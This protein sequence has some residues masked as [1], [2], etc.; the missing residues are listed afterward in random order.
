MEFNQ[1][2]TSSSCNINQRYDDPYTVIV[3]CRKQMFISH[4]G[5]E[6]DYSRHLLN[7]KS[8]EEGR[9]R[10]KVGGS[11]MFRENDD[12]YLVTSRLQKK[13]IDGKRPRWQYIYKLNSTW[14]GIEKDNPAIVSWLWDGFEAPY[15]AKKDDW[16]YLFASRTQSWKQSTTWYR[17]AKSLELLATAIDSEVVMH[18]ANTPAIQSMGSQFCFL[19]QFDDGKWLFGGRRHPAESPENFAYKYGKYV[20]APATFIDGTPHVYW[21]YYF[22]WT[23]YDYTNPD[24]D[25][26][27]HFGFGHKKVPCLDSTEAFWL[28]KAKRPRFCSWASKKNTW[29]RCQQHREM[30]VKCPVTC[31]VFGCGKDN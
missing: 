28:E 9:G 23:T 19:Q 18:P 10:L 15:I 11:S 16:Y 1:N 30:H 17:R 12:L 6:G 26:H 29:K 13:W 5:V 27:Y 21:K 22:D 31:K 24:F 3:H 25:T 2:Q 14:T 7:I 20:M 4:N 8:N